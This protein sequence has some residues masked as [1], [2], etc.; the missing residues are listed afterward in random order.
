MADPGS[1]MDG[2]NKHAAA[3]SQRVTARRSRTPRRPALRVLTTREIDPSDLK[4]PALYINREL[5]WLEFNERVLA[6]ARDTSHPLLERVKFLAI[7]ATNLD[8]FFM[9]RVS[10]TL[11]NLREGIEDVAPDGYNTEQQLEAMRTRARRMME[12]QSRCWA[13]LRTLLEAEQIRCLEPDAWSPEVREFLTAYFGREVAPVLT[14]L[15]FDPGHPFPL[16]SN[17]SKNFAVVVRHGGR[18]KFARVKLPDVLPRFVT[19][20]EALAGRPGLS[21]AFLEDV[22][23]TNMQEL[24]PGTQ[25]QGAHL[26]RVIRDADLEIEE[27]EADDLLESVD[28]SLKQ[29]RRGALALLQ[30]EADMPTRVLNI[31][32]ENFEVTD[33]VVLRTTDRLGFGD[34]AQLTRIHR[35]E[36]K[37]APFQPRTLWRADE[38]PESI[39]DWIRYQDVLVHHPFESFGS[40]ETFLRAAV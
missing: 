21:F 19:I 18:T 16:I 39:F 15:A 35:P 9:I 10:T 2:S 7:T 8:E 12:D 29:L 20:P 6:Q 27:D 13:D 3:G 24:F 32:V 31:L 22:V 25:V 14:P 37:D 1:F 30:V 5:S 36:L 34:W 40:V 28:R 26:F 11:K 33:D 23:R 4:N 38:D 17:L